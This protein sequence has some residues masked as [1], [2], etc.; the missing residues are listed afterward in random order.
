MPLT[1]FDFEQQLFS[2]IMSIK[3]EFP[4]SRANL[5]Q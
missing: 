3:P 2:E 4:R 1:L 5:A